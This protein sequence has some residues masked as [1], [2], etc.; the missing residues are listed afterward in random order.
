NLMHGNGRVGFATRSRLFWTPTRYL[1]CSWLWSAGRLL[2][3]VVRLPGGAVPVLARLSA[4]PASSLEGTG[5]TD[6][7]P[8][9]RDPAPA[10]DVTAANSC[11]SSAAASVEPLVSAVRVGELPRHA[12]GAVALAP[13]ARRWP[14]D[15]SN[16]KPGRPPLDS[17]LRALMNPH[18]G[19]RRIAGELNGA[20]V[21][22]SATCVRKTLLE[23]GLQPAPTRSRSTCR[24]FL[25]RQAGSTPACDFLTAETVFLGRIY[26][27]FFISPAT[28][29]VEYL[30]CSSNPDGRLVAQQARTLLMQVGDMQPS[31][32]LIDDAKF[33][34]AFDEV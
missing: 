24:A 30:A 10:E 17:S 23:R 15:V 21:A 6:P 1:R 29:R 14:L 7:A 11:R 8:R 26:V 3:L 31:R 12:G 4:W 28:R 34:H 25:R 2:A 33:S 20:G 18:W 13:P 9:A 22:V 5:D 19:D 16:R 27:L 32:F